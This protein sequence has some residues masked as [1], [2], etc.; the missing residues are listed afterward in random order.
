[1]IQ[2]VIPAAGTAVR[3]GGCPKE[4]LPVSDSD[5]GLTR[6]VRLAHR[7]GY[8]D[9]VVVTNQVKETLHRA[10]LAAAGLDAK[11]IVKLCPEEGDMWGSVLLGIDETANGG[12][13]LP[14]SLVELTQPTKQSGAISFGCFA[15]TTPWRFSCLEFTG[16]FGP[17]ILTKPQHLGCGLAWGMVTWNADAAK[18]LK[19][20]P[21]N[22]D[23]AFESVAR[24]SG[25]GIFMLHSYRDLG[26][27]EHYTEYLNEHRFA[28]HNA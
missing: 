16:D 4:L 18:Q 24:N 22:F 10:T 14:D 17:K 21:V 25:F 19:S 20:H 26:S 7:L 28:D 9:P 27:F 2:F 3:F 12:L 13:L 5:C 23:Q 8:C 15:T 1:M 11:F 6:A